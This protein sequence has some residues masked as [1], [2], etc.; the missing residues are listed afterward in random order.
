MYV[1]II[2]INVNRDSGRRSGRTRD[3]GEHVGDVKSNQI[4]SKTKLRVST[5]MPTYNIQHACSRN[6][7]W[8]STIIIQIVQSSMIFLLLTGCTTLCCELRISWDVEHEQKK[9]PA[10]HLRPPCIV[11]VI[12][13][14]VIGTKRT[15]VRHNAQIWLIFTFFMI[16]LESLPA[17][18][19]GEGCNNRARRG[20]T[21][22]MWFS[23]AHHKI[24]IVVSAFCENVLFLLSTLKNKAFEYCY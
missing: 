21:C 13:V 20:S 10:R 18:N 2:Y 19:W 23:C 16:S 3:G 12:V 24:S 7:H 11:V 1:Y 17:Q 15:N 6:T 4:K 9:T 14:P 5:F 8:N 22:H